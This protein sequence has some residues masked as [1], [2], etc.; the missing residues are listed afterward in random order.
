MIKQFKQKVGKD[1]DKD[2]FSM[3]FPAASTAASPAL[4]NLFTHTAHDSHPKF[5]SL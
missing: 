3:V 5:S 4:A 1:E 2:T